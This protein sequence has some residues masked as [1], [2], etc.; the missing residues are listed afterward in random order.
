MDFLM[1]KENLQLHKGNMLEI[2]KMD[3]NMVMGNLNGLMEAL[4]EETIIK[5]YA[6]DLENTLIAR[7]RAYQKEFGKKVY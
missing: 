5:V 4:I 2:L 1:E 7:I 3:N 6:K